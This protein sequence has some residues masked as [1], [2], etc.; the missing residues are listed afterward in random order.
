MTSIH[1]LSYLL[2]N[3]A[4]SD[5]RVSVYS[6]VYPVCILLVCIQAFDLVFIIFKLGT[7]VTNE[8][9]AF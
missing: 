6:A 5:S 7:T 3:I 9:D 8:D 1:V 2:Y 4:Q